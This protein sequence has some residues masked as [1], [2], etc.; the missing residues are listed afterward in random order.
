MKFRVFRFSRFDPNPGSTYTTS[1]INEVKEPFQIFL[2]FYEEIF[3]H[4]QKT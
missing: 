2:F 3:T 1:N 4:T